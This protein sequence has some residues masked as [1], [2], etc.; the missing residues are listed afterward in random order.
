MSLLYFQPPQVKHIVSRARI[1]IKKDF[2]DAAMKEFVD[3]LLNMVLQY[4]LCHRH[5]DKVTM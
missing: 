2:S 4:C 1:A 3:T 5:A